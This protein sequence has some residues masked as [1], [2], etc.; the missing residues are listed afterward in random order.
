[1]SPIRL[2]LEPQASCISVQ[3]RRIF[4]K[5][6]TLGLGSLATLGSRNAKAGPSAVAARR[7]EAAG[8]K[9]SGA[10]TA[11][12]V[13]FLDGGPSHHET[14]DPKPEAPA[15]VRGEFDVIDTSVP[16]IQVSEH[17]PLLAGQAQHYAL[18][19]SLHH[20]SPSHAPAEHQMLTGWMGSRPGTARAVIETPSFGSILSCLRGPRREG[21]PAY[22]AVPWSF[23]HEY[24]GS[25]F[26][27]ASHLGP[28]FEPF[29]S[30]HLPKQATAAYEVPELKLPAG[31][32]A[33]RLQNRRT[34]LGRLDRFVSDGGTAPEE[35][36]R[37]RAFTE[38]AMD[39][40]VNS[41]VRDA[42]DF[43]REPV[44]L[45]ERYGSHEWGQGALLARRLVEAGVTFVM[46]QCGLRQDWDT[47]QQ[48]FPTLKDKLL[49]PMDRAVSALF[50][51]LA[52]RG[53]LE[54]TLV[55]VIGEFGRTPKI[56]EITSNN[57]TDASGRDHWANCF[58][59]LIGGGG[60][61]AAQ[62]VGSSDN[63]GAYPHTRALHAQDLFATMYHTLGI[64]PHTIFH[65]QDRP[66][67]ILSHGT[68]ILELL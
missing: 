66:V 38:E 57:M 48:N 47:H 50:A 18:V 52:Q 59:G 34:L 13:F 61:K 11:C 10:E 45:R 2:S 19:R 22:V 7:A 24:G 4:L 56:G 49:P 15:E 67:P 63:L 68:P 3:A 40:L 33:A 17:L 58:S 8:A 62:V 9:T 39:M 32:S 36:K 5:A 25:P 1:M 23:H 16:G 60:L 46:L 20:G 35:L 54:K 42:F 43:A 26:G 64:D 55:L 41:R 29:E 14:F 12:I 37:A 31:M 44:S 6:A 51:D 53:L 27:A 65:N 30:G 21:L 28:R